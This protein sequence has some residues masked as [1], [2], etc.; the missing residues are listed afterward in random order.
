MSLTVPQ[1]IM[2]NHAAWKT[3]K[4]QKTKDHGS[5]NESPPDF[6]SMSP[7]KLDSYYARWD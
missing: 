5:V 4:A 1:I 7:D 3:S 2:L 6:N